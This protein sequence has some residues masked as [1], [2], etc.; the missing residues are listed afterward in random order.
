VKAAAAPRAAAPVATAAAADD[1]PK[2][3]ANPFAGG[4]LS[5]IQVFMCRFMNILDLMT[6]SG[7]SEIEKGDH[8]W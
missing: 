8:S 7:G 1:T 6:E 2:R 4:L 5:E 3:P